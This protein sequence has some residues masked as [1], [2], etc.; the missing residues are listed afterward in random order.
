MT[1]SQFFYLKEKLSSCIDIIPDDKT[2]SFMEE[3]KNIMD[4][5][6]PNDTP[7]IALALAVEN[8]GIWSGDR[9]FEQQDKVKVWTTKN[10]L[11]LFCSG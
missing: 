6:D 3:A 2:L 4:A 1:P 11:E 8:D 7:F 10:L 5:I 9:H